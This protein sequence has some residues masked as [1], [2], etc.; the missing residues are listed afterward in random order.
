MILFVLSRTFTIRRQAYELG[1]RLDVARLEMTR[2]LEKQDGVLRKM[3]LNS[4]TQSLQ[5]FFWCFEIILNIKF[6]D[7][8]EYF[9]EAMDRFC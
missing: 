5:K 6:Y 3:R 8:P 9:Y 4:M 2:M 1:E 7:I